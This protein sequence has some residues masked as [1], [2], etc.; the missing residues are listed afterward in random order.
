[1]MIKRF[2]LVFYPSL[3]NQQYLSFSQ[4]WIKRK[5]HTYV[6]DTLPYQLANSALIEIFSSDF[7]KTYNL[8]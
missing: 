2:I 7:T 4:R 5:T 1:M 3:L 6:M 8:L